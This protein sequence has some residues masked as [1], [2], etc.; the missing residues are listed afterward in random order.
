MA[1]HPCVLV[2]VPNGDVQMLRLYELQCGQPNGKLA[3]DFLVLLT[4]AVCPPMQLRHQVLFQPL[5]YNINTLININRRHVALAAK[6]YVRSWHGT[7][8]NMAQWARGIVTPPQRH[9]FPPRSRFSTAGSYGR[10]PLC[11]S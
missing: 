3:V 8:G 6:I 4:N 7:R 5:Q 9:R 1:Y 2:V 10:L 11:D